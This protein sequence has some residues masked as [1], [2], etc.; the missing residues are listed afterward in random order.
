LHAV[1]KRRKRRGKV[2][3]EKHRRK[4]ARKACQ[5]NLT[6]DRDPPKESSNPAPE[7]KR[8]K[9]EKGEVG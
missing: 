7:R 2:I 9:D 4:E 6:P 3:V 1:E 5:R 8:K